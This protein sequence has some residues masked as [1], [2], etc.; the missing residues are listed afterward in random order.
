MDQS[1]T[2]LTKN[3][4]EK[5][6]TERWHL[7]ENDINNSEDIKKTV[8][9]EFLLGICSEIRKE[10]EGEFDSNYLRCML[11]ISESSAR[12]RKDIKSDKLSFK[13]NNAY[14]IPLPVKPSFKVARDALIADLK[15]TEETSMSYH[16]LEEKFTRIKKGSP[17]IMVGVFDVVI[18]L[19]KHNFLLTEKKGKLVNHGDIPSASTCSIEK[20]ETEKSNKN[21]VRALYERFKKLE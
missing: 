12:L 15:S 17:L 9:S 20:K 18:H 5:L 8:I 10:Y 7:Q 14:H 6:L 13:V 2:P 19:V 11:I 4:M 1:K 16:D 21:S 3:R